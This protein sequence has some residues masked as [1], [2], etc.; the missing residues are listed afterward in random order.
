M[1]VHDVHTVHTYTIQQK[2]KNDSDAA[3]AMLAAHATHWQD[4][5]DVDDDTGGQPHE[6]V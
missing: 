3:A 6:S 5:A 2:R 1:Y 4:E